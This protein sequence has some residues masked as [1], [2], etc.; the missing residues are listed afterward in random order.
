MKIFERKIEELISSEVG[1]SS[2][3]DNGTKKKI[4]KKI[5]K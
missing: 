5:N 3:E 4:A 1:E 2:P